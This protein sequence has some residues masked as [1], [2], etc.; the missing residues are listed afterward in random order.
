MDFYWPPLHWHGL[1][2][3]EANQLRLVSYIPQQE[4]PPSL[5]NPSSMPHSLRLMKSINPEACSI[6]KFFP[7]LKTAPATRSFLRKKQKNCYPKT[8]C[9]LCLD[10]IQPHPGRPYYPRSNVIMDCC[11][12]RHFM[13]A[14]KFPPIFCTSVLKQR[15]QVFH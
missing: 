11:T 13:K 3:G 9:R 5:K 8:L 2:E 7:S 6:E 12:I 10:V 4:R 15:N 14:W 1:P